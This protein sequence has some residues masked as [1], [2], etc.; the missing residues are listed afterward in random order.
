MLTYAEKV[1]KDAH[2]VTDQEFEQLRAVLRDYDP[3]IRP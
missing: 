1:A 3:R 2:S